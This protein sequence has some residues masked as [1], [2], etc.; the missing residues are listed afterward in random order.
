MINNKELRNLIL[1]GS[2]CTLIVSACGYGFYGMAAGALP[3][4]LG[5][6]L[7]SLFFHYRDDANKNSFIQYIQRD[8]PN[9]IFSSC[10]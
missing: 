10:A 5:S 7:S 9:F 1:L 4:L 3:L 2:V 6:V 8:K